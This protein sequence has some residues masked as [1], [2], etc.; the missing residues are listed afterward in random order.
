MASERVLSGLH[1]YSKRLGFQLPCS[2]AGK[3]LFC[4]LPLIS[5]CSAV[6]L[7]EAPYLVP[8]TEV[9]ARGGDGLCRDFLLALEFFFPPLPPLLLCLGLCSF[10]IILKQSPLLVSM[11]PQQYGAPAP[12]AA[13]AVAGASDDAAFAK[14]EKKPLDDAKKEKTGKK[15]KKAKVSEE[16]GRL[17]CCCFEI[18]PYYLKGARLLDERRAA[19]GWARGYWIDLRLLDERRAAIGR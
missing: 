10:E 4:S 19:I 14:G 12:A 6:P 15:E 1:P 8:S 3:S 17:D 16:S 2:F 13:P 7:P 9:E 18:W 11:P 5:F